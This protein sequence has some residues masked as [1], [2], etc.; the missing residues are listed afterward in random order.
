MAARRQTADQRPP[1]SSKQGVEIIGGEWTRVEISMIDTSLSCRMIPEYKFTACA[2]SRGP[3]A[4][5]V[6]STLTRRTA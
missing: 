1:R 2:L 3:P 4:T 5:D 6:L